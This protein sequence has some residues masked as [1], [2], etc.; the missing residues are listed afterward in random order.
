MT[1]GGTGLVAASL[2]LIAGSCV[3]PVPFAI[4]A[5]APP[6]RPFTTPPTLAIV[7]YRNAA[8][9]IDGQ[10]RQGGLLR[11]Q[12]TAGIVALDLDGAPVALARDGAFIVGFAQDAPPTAR[13]TARGRSGAPTTLDLTVISGSWRVERIAGVPRFPVPSADFAR[14]RPLEF[15]Q[16]N[17]ARRLPVDS[18]G[19]RQALVWPVTGRI[20]GLFGATRSYANGE[21]GAPHSGVDVARPTGTPIVAPAD[22]VVTLAAAAPFTLEGNL[23]LI[24]HGMGVESSFLHLSRIDVRVGDRVRQGQTVGAIG[25]TGRASGPHLHWGMRWGTV[26]VDPL[27]A[28]P[29]MPGVAK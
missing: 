7:T 15:A 12:A 27:L 2:A 23:L 10:P 14:R 8:M 28:A 4:A 11:G 21:A 19:W 20:S 25:A 29:P 13:L 9:R 24:G 5:D 1:R 3:P 16:M 18:D 17:A 6:S 26:R 22:G